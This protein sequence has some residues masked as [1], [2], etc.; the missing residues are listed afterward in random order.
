MS[1]YELNPPKQKGVNLEGLGGWLTVP[2]NHVKKFKGWPPRDAPSKLVQLWY[3]TF[4]TDQRGLAEMKTP[5]RLSNK[6]STAWSCAEDQ[7]LEN[8]KSP[9]HGFKYLYWT[10][11]KMLFWNVFT[12]KARSYGVILK[13]IFQGRCA[14]PKGHVLRLRCSFE[15]NL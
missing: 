5:T 8:K 14:L 9:E 10:I 4:P 11:S 15:V 13:L 6:S 1:S 2:M 12:C 7:I 3:K